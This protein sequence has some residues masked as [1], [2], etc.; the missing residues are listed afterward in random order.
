MFQNLSHR[1]YY[2]LFSHTTTS[3]QSP[4]KQSYVHFPVNFTRS[5]NTFSQIYGHRRDLTFISRDATSEVSFTSRGLVFC[6]YVT[7]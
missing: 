2:Q 7:G 6:Y 5:F 4:M 1:S 3:Y